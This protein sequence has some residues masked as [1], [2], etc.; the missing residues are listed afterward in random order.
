MAGLG[1]VINKNLRVFLDGQDAGSLILTHIYLLV[2]CS[3][4]LWLSS[5]TQLSGNDKIITGGWQVFEIF[6][7]FDWL[8]KCQL[9]WLCDCDIDWGKNLAPVLQPRYMYIA[10]ATF[11]VFA[12]EPR[13]QN[14]PSKHN[15]CLGCLGDES[16]GPK[17]S[18]HKITKK[19]VS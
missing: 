12:A 1:V 2:G 7:N 6:F 13:P 11:F 3:A 10:G 15:H 9:Y 18:T 8:Y 16:W 4:P 17:T 14:T 5:P 19:I